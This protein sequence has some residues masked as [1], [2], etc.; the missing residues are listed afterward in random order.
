MIATTTPPLI[1]T[2]WDDGQA[3]D[4]RVA[5]ILA[6]RGLRA[7]FYVFGRAAAPEELSP[8]AL[9]EL[10]TMGMEIGSHGI[11]HVDFTRVSADVRRRELADSRSYLEDL[12]QQPIRA[13][14]FPFGGFH[15]SMKAE[16]R[17]AGYSFAR[18]TVSFRLSAP[19]PELLPVTF[20][21]RRQRPDI[22]VRHALKEGNL[23]GLARWLRTFKGATDPAA[24]TGKALRNLAPGG[25][26][27]IWG[28]AEELEGDGLWPLLERVADEL[29]AA[30]TA[31]CVTNG[32]VVNG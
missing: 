10:M 9:H 12:L 7:T 28:H 6:A 31:R 22:V 26:L 29:A 17:A 21:L 11:S 1:T 2:S 20:L 13:F 5:E 8:A 3:S 16:V 23:Q 25:V 24:L 14:C 18:T 19:D 32:A 27:H 4:M 15:P 30:A